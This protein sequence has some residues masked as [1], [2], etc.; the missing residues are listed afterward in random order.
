[1][2]ILRFTETEKKRAKTNLVNESLMLAVNIMMLVFFIRIEL[3]AMIVICSLIIGAYVPRV[4]HG[5]FF[6]RVFK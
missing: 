3:I 1:M 5:I 2:K 6:Y 4:Y